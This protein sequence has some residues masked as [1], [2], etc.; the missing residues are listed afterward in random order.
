MK[1]IDRFNKFSKPLHNG[2]DQLKNLIFDRYPV[3]RIDDYC[4]LD[5]VY[6]QNIDSDYVW[7][8]D[9]NIKVFDSFPWWFKPRSNDIIQIHE[10]PYVYK[11]SRK[12]KSWD[13]V[14]LVPTK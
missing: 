12:I 8:V 14:R 10:F 7:V 2:Q 6:Q 9:K 3:L 11:E 5:K 13:K 1:A 4:D